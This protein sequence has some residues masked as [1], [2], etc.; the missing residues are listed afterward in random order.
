MPLLFII[1]QILFFEATRLSESTQPCGG[2]ALRTV[3]AP[4]ACRRRLFIS[5]NT[6]QS[7]TP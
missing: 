3:A 4:E 2:R 1:C 7:G 6:E 5:V